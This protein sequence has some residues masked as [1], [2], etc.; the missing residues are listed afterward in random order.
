MD[1]ALQRWKFLLE[2][3]EKQAFLQQILVPEQ[4]IRCSP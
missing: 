4:F 3:W 1:E 2:E